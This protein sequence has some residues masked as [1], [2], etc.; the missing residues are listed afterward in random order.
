[1]VFVEVNYADEYPEFAENYNLNDIVSPVDADKLA[2]L[3]KQSQYDQK[4]INYL[5]KGFTQGFDIRYQEPK[6]CASTAKNILIRVGS[7]TILWNKLIKEVKLGRVAGPYDQV[8]YENYIQSPIGLVPKG[9]PKSGKTHLIFHLSYDF[10][11][12]VEQKLLNFH[13]PDNLC[14]VK[15]NDL[16]HAIANCIVA[17]KEA[18]EQAKTNYAEQKKDNIVFQEEIGEVN[19]ATKGTI[20]LSKTDVQG[21]VH[22]VPLAVHCFAWLVMC[23][24]NPKSRKW[25]FFIDKCLPFG[26]S[27]SCAIFQRFSNALCHITKFKTSM[28]TITNYLDDF[29]F[30]AYMK[31]LCDMMVCRFLQICETIGIPIAKEKTVWATNLLYF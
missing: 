25:Q 29:L 12:E 9:Q 13:T 24:R 30:V 22:L 19:S 2:F 8:P 11:P 1:M 5:Y 15:Y 7:E 18:D 6:V 10:G 27:I 23:A 20:F 3:L 21:A 17:K 31:A 14:L 28:E 26:A 4:E 16:D